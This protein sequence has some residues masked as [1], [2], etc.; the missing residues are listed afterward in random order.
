MTLLMF[1]MSRLLDVCL[2]IYYDTNILFFFNSSSES[3]LSTAQYTQIYFESFWEN[4]SY[5]KWFN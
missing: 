4:V 5:F 2:G 1:P 3:M